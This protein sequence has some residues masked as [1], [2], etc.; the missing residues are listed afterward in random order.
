MGSKSPFSLASS[1]TDQ[2]CNAQDFIIRPILYKL[3]AISLLSLLLMLVI[4]IYFEKK[5]LYW[6][7]GTILHRQ[8]L[9]TEIG[10]C[11]LFVNIG[12]FYRSKYTMHI[13]FYVRNRFTKPFHYKAYNQCSQNSLVYNNIIIIIWSCS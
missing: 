8:T 3:H 2:N 11:F 4:K 1:S 10:C 6:A 9:F 7:I 12:L 5:K 13:N